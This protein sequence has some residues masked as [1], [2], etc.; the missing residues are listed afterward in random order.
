MSKFIIILIFGISSTALADEYRS[1]S[2]KDGRTIKAKVLKVNTQAKKVTMERDNKK[3]TTVPIRVFSETDQEYINA[4]SPSSSGA[5]PVTQPL[6]PVSRAH[7]HNDYLH[8]RP[9]L[10]ALENGFSSVEADVFLKNGD[11]LLGHDLSQTMEGRNLDALYLQPLAKRVQHSDN[12]RVHQH[13]ETFYLLIDFKT[14]GKAAYELLKKQIKP[15]RTLLTEFSNT[16]TKTNAVT[17]IIT[18]NCP[19]SKMTKEEQR[20]AGCDGFVS[21]LDAKPNQHLMPWMS[22]KWGEF[23]KWNGSGTMPQK[24]Q[25]KLESLVQKAHANGQAIRFWAAPDN[26]ASWAAQQKVGVDFINSDR[27]QDLAHFLK[28]SS[29]EVQRK[30]NAKTATP[31]RA[32]AQ[33]ATMTNPI[34]THGQDPWVVQYEGA[35]YYC[36]SHN[37]SIWINRHQTLQKACQFKGKRIWTPPAGTSYSKDIWA[38]EIHNIGGHWYV[39]FAADDGNNANHRMYVLKSQ[40]NDPQGRYTFMGKISDATDKWA[41]DGTVLE[42]AGSLYFIWSGWDG[43]ENGQQELYIAKMKDPKTIVGKRVMISEPEYDW[44][45]IGNPYINEGPQ[46]LKNQ[47]TVF[48]IYSASGSW[49]DDYCLGQL[50]LRGSDPLKHGSWKKSRKPVFSGTGTVFSPGHASF[51][52]SPNC[53]EDWMVYHTA[54]HKGAGWDRD[55][56]IKRFTWDIKGDPVFGDPSKGV[57]IPTPGSK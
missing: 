41:I 53:K 42:H 30:R 18:G 10:D 37:G 43:D 46:V 20:W 14:D 55:I 52:K 57:M 13:A 36:Y 54:K 39:Y 5:K 38:P 23:F 2:D 33:Q 3:E 24:E 6:T 4:W 34:A 25:A 7:A 44:E 12:N 19:I 15:Y 27:L 35:Y 31:T 45:T 50:Q 11:L 8:Q 32:I 47:G 17:I 48:I 28:S 22:G 51:V 16:A 9:L 49:T 26:R 1:F 21:N 40:T 29:K 56:N